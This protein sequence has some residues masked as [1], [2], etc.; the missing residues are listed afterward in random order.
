MFLM[1]F[2]YLSVFFTLGLLVSARTNKKLDQL[3][4]PALHLVIFV[5]I[6]PKVSVLTAAQLNPIL[7]R[8]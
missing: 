4:R 3:P 1:F 8:A 6:I 7:F 2:L 5:T